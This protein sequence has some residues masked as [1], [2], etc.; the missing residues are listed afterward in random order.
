MLL[1][2]SI[3]SD[4]NINYSNCC[5]IMEQLRLTV[6]RQDMTCHKLTDEIIEQ[7]DLSNSVYHF[8]YF[9]L[10]MAFAVGH[11]AGWS[12]QGRK[13]KPVVQL[14]K[15]NKIIRQYP[16]LVHA[17]AAVGSQQN[18]ISRCARGLKNHKTCKGFKWKYLEDFTN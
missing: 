13:R 4:S 2:D 9:R 10:R 14:T 3:C 15:D 17:A 1:Y 6:I 5:A 11:D 8:I 12:R 16:S 7:L 18:N